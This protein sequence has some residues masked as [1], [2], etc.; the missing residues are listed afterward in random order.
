M[1]EKMKLGDNVKLNIVDPE[2]PETDT[3]APVWPKDNILIGTK[4]REKGS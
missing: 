3:K 4:V 1:K 2:V